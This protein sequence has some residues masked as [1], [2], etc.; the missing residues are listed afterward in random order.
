MC[1]DRVCKGASDVVALACVSWGSR[2]A[3]LTFTVQLLTAS[4]AIVGSNSL[5]LSPISAA[6]AGS[7]PGAAPADVMVAAAAYGLGTAVSALTLAPISDRV[8]ADK[9]LMWA[10]AV[11]VVAL[12]ASGLA[13]A[14]WVL[15]LT[16][17]VAGLAAGAALP[18]IYTRAAQIAP[19]GRESETLGVVLTGWTISMAAGVS[20][21]AVLADLMHWRWV[22]VGLAA[23]ALV[24]ALLLRTPAARRIP[25]AVGAATSPLTALRVP[26][27]TRGLATCAAYMIAFYGVYTY[28]GAHVQGGLGRSTMAA[29]L[30]T[31]SY[32]IGFGTAVR[33]DRLLDRHGPERLAL[34][35]FGALTLV[36]VGMAAIAAS[37]A[38]LVLLCLAWG[39]ANHLALNVIVG[40]LTALDAGQRGAIMGLYSAT[41]YLCVFVGAVMYRPV[42]D[43]GGLAGGAALS[44]LF[45][46][47]PVVSTLAA[48]RRQSG[49][50][51]IRNS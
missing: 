2:A 3:V 18:S 17:A 42:F 33:L 27:I 50:R 9:A 5:V 39:L 48:R 12:A 43:F 29:G 4:V 31:L 22:Y 40:R 21:S 25:A 51:P 49:F 15:S 38:G 11:L 24:V 23:G 46:S 16:Q 34:P 32:G 19:E 26:G 47:L 1:A 37:F 6:V 7:F 14:L 35:V 30:A 28:L 44:V 8:G 20:L 41:T 13:P 10:M 36:Y 45:I